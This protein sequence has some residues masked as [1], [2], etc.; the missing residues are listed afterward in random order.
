[1]ENNSTPL[2]KIGE[3][4][5]RAGLTVRSLHHYDRVGL[6]RPSARSA[7]GYRLYN[8]EDIARL[9][10]VQTLQRLGLSL[11]EI[12]LA[13]DQPQTRLPVL[14]A[15]QRQQLAQQIEHATQ[16]QTRLGQLQAELERGDEPDVNDWLKTLELMNMYDKYFTPD[17]L[18]RLPF[19]RPDSVRDA[20]W[21][22]LVATV[23][24]LMDSQ[25]PTD[26]PRAR[27]VARQWFTRVEQDIASDPRLLTK[28][29]DMHFKEP[30]MQ[31]QTGITPQ[32]IHYVQ[33]A[34]IHD[35][36]DI[37]EKYLT[38]G[39]FTFVKQNYGKRVSEWPQLIAAVYAAM[40]DG[41]PANALEA[42]KLAHQWL[43]LFRSYTGNN[44]DTQVKIRAAH[45]QEP[46]L[47]TGS[48]IT[49]ELLTYMRAAFSQL[50]G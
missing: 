45:E 23:R 48:L 49:P 21:A 16:L 1:M 26:D 2:L 30:A 29:T 37:Y 6:L 11:A 19:H 24:A 22:T 9:H 8:H 20:A 46:G 14:I 3:L 13:L 41:V 34:S 15:R 40:Q 27:D 17:E 4:A 5:R 44:P 39:E 31:N 32:V 47:L 28:L 50:H 43:D 33:Q 42:K 7:A 36:L 25:T 10:Q 38:P 12:G 35:K 18:Q